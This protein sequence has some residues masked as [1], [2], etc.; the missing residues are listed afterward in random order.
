MAGIGPK[1]AAEL[2]RRFD[3]LETLFQQ[4][5]QVEEKWR[6]KLQGAQEIALIS[7]QVARLA[8]CLDLQGNLK[9]LRYLPA[10]GR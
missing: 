6:K 7:R 3:N 4:L 10:T 9:S 5:D 8:T 1:S 2:I